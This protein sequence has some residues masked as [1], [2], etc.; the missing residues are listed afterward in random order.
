MQTETVQESVERENDR[1]HP[2]D[3]TGLRVYF[4][5]PKGAYATTVLG[6][7]FQLSEPVLADS[8]A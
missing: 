6:A 2:E 8:P 7:V 1:G 4:V 5:L 3:V